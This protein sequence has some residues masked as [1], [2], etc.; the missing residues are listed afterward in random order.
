MGWQIG[1]TVMVLVLFVIFLLIVLYISKKFAAQSNQLKTSQQHYQSLYHYNPDMILTLDKEG[2]LLSANEVVESYGYKVEEII[3]EP[4]SAYVV[5]E[6]LKKTHENFKKSIKGTAT[7][8]ETTIYSKDGKRIELNVTSIPIVINEKI[9]G[10]YAILKDITRFK[11]AQNALVEAES[12]YRSLVEESLIGIYIIQNGKFVY[13]NPQILEWFGYTYEET[14]GSHL[15]NYIHPEDV[16]IVEENI[17]KRL[18]GGIKGVRFQYRGIRKDQNVIYMEVY[19]SQTIYQGRP[20]IIGS[21]IDITEQKKAEEKIKHMAYHDALTGLPNRY[22]LRSRF[23][24]ALMDKNMKLAAILFL[25]LDRF[26]LINDTLGHELGDQLLKKVAERLRECVGVGDCLARL[27]GDEFILFLPHTD[28]ERASRAAKKVLATLNESFLLN[29]YEIYITPSMGISQYPCDGEDIA[30]LIKKADLAMHQAKRLGKNNFQYYEKKSMEQ[31]TNRLELE[32]DLRKALERKEFILY[33]QPKLSIYSGEIIG[34]EALIRWS[35]PDKGIISPTEFIPLAEE[36]GMIIPIGEWVLRKACTEIQA[37]NKAGFPPMVVSVNLSLR[38]FFQPNF[39]Q[40][41]GQVLSETGLPPE[42]L[43]LE[44]TESMTIDTHHALM[45]VSEL[46]KL[47]VRISLDDFGTGYSSLHYL[48]QFPVDKLKIDRSFIRDCLTDSNNATIVKTIIAM[49]HELKME[50]NAEGVETEEQL[51]FLQQN[52]CNEV[53]GYLFSKPLPIEEIK[54][55]YHDIARL[56]N[57]LSVTG[58]QTMAHE[59]LS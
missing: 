11:Y 54:E 34:V 23:Q 8:Y 24:S 26:K 3:N 57:R 1:I 14:I 47:G 52:S 16:T 51:A 13:V 44:I 39:T 27:G 7:N 6:M 55:N 12:K 33:Y 38:Q 59:I 19:G 42:S 21:V 36:T 15:I 30:T 32:K 20:A 28:Q 37:L 56:A 18:Q 58:E 53:Q 50:I 31:S 2:K 29:E 46:K 35:H 5:P 9:V 22:Q 48:K 25:D 41:V 10:A 45:I 17:Q 43:E 4:F 49:A 40:M